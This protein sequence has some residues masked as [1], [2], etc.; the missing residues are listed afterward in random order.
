MDLK[1]AIRTIADFPKPGIM[2]RDVTTLFAAPAGLRTAVERIVRRYEGIDI[3]KVAGIEARGFILGGALA[4]ELARGFIA[5]RK[6]GKLPWNTLAQHYDLEYGTDTVEIH[7]DA[8]APGER[9]LIVDDLLATGGTAEATTKLIQR[10]GG[11]VAGCCFL[12]DLPELGGRKRLEKMG[13]TV[14]CLVEFD[15]H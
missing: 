11:T 5:V 1:L 15:G 4:H 2:F 10:A 3:D 6:A 14:Q 7:L 13:V 8:V 9:I 12:V